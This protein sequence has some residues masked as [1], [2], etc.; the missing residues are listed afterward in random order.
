MPAGHHHAYKGELYYEH[1]DCSGGKPKA[2]STPA[3]VTP[4]ACFAALEAEDI[5]LGS[6]IAVLEKKGFQL[7]EKNVTSMKG[8]FSSPRASVLLELVQGCDAKEPSVDPLEPVYIRASE[9]EINYAKN[10][11]LDQKSE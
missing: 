8:L 10:F 7:A 11:G 4:G 9:A 3:L 2:L 1:F 6:G 5:L